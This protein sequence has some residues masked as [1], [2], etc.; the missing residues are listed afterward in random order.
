MLL[1]IILPVAVLLPP[2]ACGTH[3]SLVNAAR[4]MSAFHV[5]A[6]AGAI[7][8]TRLPSESLYASNLC[9]GGAS[10]LIVRSMSSDSPDAVRLPGCAAAMAGCAPALTGA[11]VAP[12]TIG[13]G[14]ML[15][16]AG[17]LRDA[18]VL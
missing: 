1:L 10:P 9:S 14:L 8:V 18:R 7:A 5:Q 13:D 11:V 6:L 4:R 2:P 15:L 12:C 17:V 16:D 3:V